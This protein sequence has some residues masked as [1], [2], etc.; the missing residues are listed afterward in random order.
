MKT[1]L[2]F[3]L[4]LA[5]IAGL[6]GRARG[7]GKVYMEGVPANIP[8]Q[9]A[10]ILFH[11]GSQMLVLQSKFELSQSAEAGSLGW[12]VPVPSVPEI[13][14][15]NPDEAQTF[16]FITSL[17]VRPNVFRISIIFL[18]IAMLPFLGGVALLLVCLAQRPFLNKI[19]L[20]K[21]AWYRRL[22]ISLLMICI[23]FLLIIVTMP[24][25]G[26]VSG[27]EIVKAQKAGIYDVKVI[28]SEKAD[29]IVDWLKE[30][31]FSFSEKDTQVF[32]DYVNR[33]WCFVV[34][35]VEPDSEIEANKIVGYKGMVAPLVLKFETAKPVYPLALT[36]TIGAD[37]E[38][39]I[40]TLSE[41]K[42]RCDEKVKLRVAK[43]I[44]TS[45]FIDHLMKYVV[46]PQT[47]GNF[48]DM[49]KSMFICKFKERL[50]PEEM[51]RDI[52]FEF[53]QDNEPYKERIIVW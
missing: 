46:K 39:L 31:S 34:A 21:A 16:F 51:K 52:Q 10:F 37:T 1:A 49:P 6:V 38:V 29:A 41:K 50:S 53:A 23:G 17:Q 26:G 27:V 20:S 11:E 3:M 9:R 8:Y 4:L 25:M 44:R 32:E 28:K 42:L 5:A 35:K 48:D 45:D 12:V 19:G 15:A 18:P 36:S 43:N 33:N 22:K 30:N 7:D 13:G 40:Y 24:S 47:F 14:S 2:K